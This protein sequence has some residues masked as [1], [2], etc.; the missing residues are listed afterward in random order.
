MNI[1]SISRHCTRWAVCRKS[2]GA[3]VPWLR[4][5]YRSIGI[6]FGGKKKSEHLTVPVMKEELLKRKS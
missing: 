3:L 4:T 1:I 5:V 2:I 6:N